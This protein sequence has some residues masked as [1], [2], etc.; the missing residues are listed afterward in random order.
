VSEGSSTSSRFGGGFAAVRGGGVPGDPG[1]P[2]AREAP[3]LAAATRLAVA[4]AVGQLAEA[5][6]L[7]AVFASGQ[8]EEELEQV[9]PL[10]QQL[11]GAGH[12]IGCSAAGVCGGG[13]AVLGEPGVSAWAAVV[14][15]LRVRVFHL[16]VMRSDEGLAVVGLPQP[17]EG[18]SAALLFADP[19]SFPVVSFIDRSPEALPGISLVGGLAGGPGGAGT[20]RLYLDGRSVDRG[21]VGMLLAGN[22]GPVVVSQGCRPVGPEMVVTAA[23]GS[24]VLELAGAPAL[25]RL[26]ELM[27]GLT[28]SEQLSFGGGPQL[29]LAMDEYADEHETGDYLIRA[30]I[31]I[32]EQ[33]GGLAIADLVEVGRTVRFQLR[34]ADAARA[35]LRSR[36]AVVQAPGPARGALLI[37]CNGRGPGMFGRADS[38]VTLVAECLGGAP[39]A[40]MFAGGEIGPVGG[41]SWLHAFTASVLAFR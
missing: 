32:D 29:G 13:H 30:V 15:D 11:S 19:Y 12:V 16:E 22:V 5:P 8:S 34:D 20:T 39:V 3:D 7:L 18:E 41:R 4:A 14:P 1:V 28:A 40:G 2:G 31:G 27:A 17:R 6:D 37:S 24:M 38:D 10:A 33:R 21:A 35:D 9:G 25:R 26:R 23:D 36:L